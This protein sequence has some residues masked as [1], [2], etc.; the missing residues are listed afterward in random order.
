MIENI[1][2]Q[3]F[4]AETIQHQKQ[5]DSLA[6]R[7]DQLHKTYSNGFN[8]LGVNYA[9]RGYPIADGGNLHSSLHSE[10]NELLRF[11][12][13]V[14]SDKNIITQVLYRLTK[15]CQSLQEYRD[16]LPEC[17]VQFDYRF[18]GMARTREPAWT[19]EKGSRTHR[20]YLKYLTKIETYCAM[21]LLY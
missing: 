8:Y 9:R 3:L 13:D 18:S 21:H 15:N 16:A 2:M 1:V 14:D 4:R 5:I 19:L 7:N 12:W 10:M 20:Q 11:K 6:D 17:L